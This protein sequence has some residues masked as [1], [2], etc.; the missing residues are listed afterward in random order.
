M[1]IQSGATDEDDVHWAPPVAGGG[2]DT[3]RTRV[4]SACSAFAGKLAIVHG[5]YRYM[6]LAVVQA[7]GA[8]SKPLPRPTQL[9]AFY[10]YACAEASS[11]SFSGIM[12]PPKG[13][14][15]VVQI[16]GLW[17]ENLGT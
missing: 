7:R 13:M 5:A 8:N 11:R 9:D 17:W 6:G 1:D 2:R 3:S 16:A 10:R 15:T 4:D 14:A 12:V